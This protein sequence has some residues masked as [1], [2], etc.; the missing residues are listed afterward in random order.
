MLT[1]ELIRE[2]REGHVLSGK[3]AS[4]IARRDD[5]DDVL[6]KLDN[7]DHQYAE[8]HLTWSKNPPTDSRWPKTALFRS[9]EEWKDAVS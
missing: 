1:E 3:S 8:V 6:T 9:F 7:D 4:V 5:R 2:V